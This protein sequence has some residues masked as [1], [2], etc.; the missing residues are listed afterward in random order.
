MSAMNTTA[1]MLQPP[2]VQTL[3][4][5]AGLTVGAGSP[6]RSLPPAKRLAEDAA[7]F[8]M[9]VGRHLIEPDGDGWRPNVIALGAL[10]ACAR[11]EE[12]LGIHVS[13][14]RRQGFA[15]CRRGQLWTECTVGPLGVVKLSFPLRRS[16]VML[17]LTS[18]R[19]DAPD[20]GFH[21][22]GPADE[23]FVLTELLEAHREQRDGGGIAPAK[24]AQ[25]IAATAETPA[26]VVPFAVAGG[27]ALLT[28]LLESAAAV[29]V[30][31]ERL[32]AAGRVRR[33]K[34]RLLPS[35]AAAA[36]LGA[37]PKAAFSVTRVVV[38]GERA[39]ESTLHVLRAG[40][41]NLV[42]R[43]VEGEQPVFEWT[44]VTK[45]ELRSIVVASLLSEDDLQLVAEQS[46]GGPAES[47]AA[48]ALAVDVARFCAQCGAE[49][50]REAA[51]FCTSCGK[52]L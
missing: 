41:R 6:L 44:E 19:P 12:V 5:I 50:K 42:F 43:V 11:P 24:L 28:P 30:V 52:P 23:A 8:R 3:L 33:A 27:T 25:R 7:G 14:D 17:A 15:V 10:A 20:G 29:E 35:E 31:V 51:K 21:F 26:K 2:Q 38:E 36:A 48:P 1:A 13:G 18:D 9:L 40:G 39:L 47:E 45:P 37:R 46:D 4:E 32:V 49:A 34:G 16:D 22:R